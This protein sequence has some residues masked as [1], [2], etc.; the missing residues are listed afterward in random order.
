[1]NVKINIHSKNSDIEQSLKST[2]GWKLDK[3]LLNELKNFLDSLASGKVNEGKHLSDRTICKYI[4]LL[5]SPLKFINKPSKEINADMTSKWDEG[6]RKDKIISEWKKPYSQNMKKDMRLALRI[7]LKHYLGESKALELTKFFDTREIRKTPESLSEAEI[8]KLYNGVKTARERFLIA[9]MFDAGCRI[10]EFLNIRMEDIQIPQDSNNF[11]KINLLEEYSKTN[12]RNISLYWSKSF[13]AV[14][15]YHKELIQSGLTSKEQVYPLN[16]DAVR[17]YIRRLG[18]RVLNKRVNPHLLRHSSATYYASKLNRQQLCYRYGWSFSSDMPDVY[19]SRSGMNNPE[20]DKQ[21]EATQLMTLKTEL[22][23]EK[24]N[25][26]IQLEALKVESEKMKAKLDSYGQLKDIAD[27]LQILNLD[28]NKIN[29]L[30]SKNTKP[31][32]SPNDF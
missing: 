10:E 18:N 6:L 4:A 17:I 15:E 27:I 24:Q 25:N 21:M 26:K 22:E 12:G 16:Y 23:R 13:E 5:R 9:V 14:S 32:I 30:M 2:E 8:I 29:A 1:M 19:I 31:T 11:V 7:F 20:L 3:T 28:K